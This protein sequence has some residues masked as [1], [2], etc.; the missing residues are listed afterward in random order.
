M[1]RGMVVLAMLVACGPAVAQQPDA[2][3]ADDPLSTIRNRT[4]FSND[5]DPADSVIDTWLTAQLDQFRAAVAAEDG[6][7]AQAAADLRAAIRRE[8]SHA[9]STPVYLARLAARTG[10]IAVTEFAAPDNSGPVDAATA[11]AWALLD[12]N[13]TTATDALAAGLRHPQGSVRYLCAKAF[14]RLK[15]AITVDA[16]TTPKI[17][18][19]LKSAALAETDGEVLAAI[20][21]AVS[22]D[23]ARHIPE[24]IPALAEVFAARVQLRNTGQLVRVDRAEL[25]AFEYLHRIRA[26]IPQALLPPLVQQ[27]A[28]LL[29]LDVQRYESAVPGERRALE[30]RIE[31]G[32][33]LMQALVGAA[34]GDVRGAMKK[35]GP[36]A[37]AEMATALAAWVGGE[38]VEGALNKAP[39]TVPVGGLP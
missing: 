38:G 7:P 22:Y 25:I 17:I 34:G 29:T 2:G 18:E 14:D 10:R 33:S 6:D 19:R 5:N 23:D 8:L 3:A 24:V 13:R 1:A 20:Y 28:A 31:V 39:W 27:L 30:E 35:G 11:L 32:E 9:D 12:L 4:T 21:A 16:T 37:P 15:P 36:T 26:N